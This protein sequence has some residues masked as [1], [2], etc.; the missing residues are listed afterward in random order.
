MWA[1]LTAD[2]YTTLH[3]FPP[4]I[5]YILHAPF[6]YLAVLKPEAEMDI[7]VIFFFTI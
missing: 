2:S 5:V 4:S 7:I 1:T 3:K 6:L